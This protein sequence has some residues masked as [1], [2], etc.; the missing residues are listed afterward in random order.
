MLVV[1]YLKEN[2]VF[3]ENEIKNNL[4]LFK[5]CQKELP[6][7][8]LTLSKMRVPASKKMNPK[9]YLINSLKKQLSGEQP[10]KE[11]GKK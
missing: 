7:F 3:S 10:K 6:D 8:I 9:G 11:A 4:D 1:N 2:F 5:Q